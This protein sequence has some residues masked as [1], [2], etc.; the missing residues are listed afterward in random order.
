VRKILLSPGWI[1]RHVLLAGIVAAFWLLSR[2]QWHRAGHTHSV[3]NYGYAVEWVAF[4]GFVIFFW[5]RMLVDELRPPARPAA[6]QQ[7]APDVAPEL[8]T[9][10]YGVR[11][12]TPSLPK[13]A[14]EEEDEELA[15]YNRQLAWLAAHPK[16]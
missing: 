10:E 6:D 2:W 16:R 5:G 15:A 8:L 7:N 4:A 3:Q 9:P 11:P 14:A 1:A 13:A 12:A